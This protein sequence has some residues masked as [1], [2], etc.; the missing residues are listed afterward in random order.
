MQIARFHDVTV[1]TQTKYQRPIESALKSL[2]PD[3]PRPEFIYFDL[4]PLLQKLQGFGLGLRVYYVLWQRAARVEVARMHGQKPFDL[5]HHVTFAAFRYPALIWGHG[6]PSVWGP[7]G[8]IESVPTP[9]LPW[10]H[11]V[12]LA[13]EAFRNFSNLV[14]A[15]PY[16]DLPKRAAASD[17]VL[18]STAEMQ[19]ALA[20]LGFESELMPT[21]GLK[22]GELP[23]RSHR[24]S[25]GPLRMLY[26][27]KLIMLKGIDLA[28]KAMS[29]SGTDATLTLV[30]SGNYLP[31]AKRLVRE[32]GLENRVFFRGQ[33][34]RDEV[35][36]LY[37]EFDVMLF[38]SLHDT[39]GYAVI[40]A[41]FN[42]V[43][44]ICLD[45]GGPA[46]AV[47][48]GCGV[49]VPVVTRQQVVEG[50]ASAIRQYD[51]DRQLLIAHGRAARESILEHYD[52]D[53]KGL[54][55]NEVYQQVLAQEP[56]RRR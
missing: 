33:L 21:I 26:V 35:L 10:R 27:G 56:V 49:K 7:V 24:R 1:L 31:A 40:E 8:G 41:M 5:M 17:K 20:K 53:Q 37:P 9:L 30:G 4:N 6:V 15:S 47:R 55:M 3:Q 22:T 19:R 29:V 54:Q 48:F 34:T 11:P 36:A 50:I 45:C 39:G 44:V 38:P 52:W 12:W 42:E 2:P 51:K 16:N 28:L 32:L 25:E 18:V 43:P 23:Y 13:V 46:M 14:Q